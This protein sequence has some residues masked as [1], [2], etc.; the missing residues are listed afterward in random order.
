MFTKSSSLYTNF[1]TIL[2]NSYEMRLLMW[3]ET[4]LLKI[5]TFCFEAGIGS[6][7]VQGHSL[8]PKK[9][10]SK[11]M[12]MTPV[13]IQISNTSA[14]GLSIVSIILSL[15]FSILTFSVDLSHVCL[16]S[17]TDGMSASF[18]T[19]HYHNARVNYKHALY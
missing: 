5:V 8:W 11:N 1:H 19:R 9:N 17:I 18:T 4:S 7:H 14:H 16:K 2:F 13:Y 6:Y 15:S 10:R 12:T 3:D